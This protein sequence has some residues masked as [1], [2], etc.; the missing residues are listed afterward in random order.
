MSADVYSQIATKIVADQ[1]TIIGPIA[2]ERAQL[3]KELDIDWSKHQISVNSKNGQSVID[4]L[5][6]TYKV[7]FGQI[8]VETCKE[9]ASKLIDQLPPEQKPESLR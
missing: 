1:E 6:E 8:A 5:V 4:R 7:L 3:I 9:A 2:I